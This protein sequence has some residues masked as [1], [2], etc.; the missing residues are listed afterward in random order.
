MTIYYANSL[1]LIINSIVGIINKPVFMLDMV[2][3]TI[4]CKTVTII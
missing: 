2:N 1:Y 3:I 4:T